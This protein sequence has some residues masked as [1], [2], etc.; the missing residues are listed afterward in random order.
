MIHKNDGTKGTVPGHAFHMKGDGYSMYDTRIK[1]SKQI[2]AV[3][4]K[5]MI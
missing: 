3:M 5:C 2:L 4:I 1:K